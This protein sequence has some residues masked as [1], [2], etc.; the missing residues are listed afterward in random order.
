MAVLPAS[1]S[2]HLNAWYPQRLE[3]GKKAT[4][5]ELKSLQTLDKGS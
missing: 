4:T 1:M 2:V 3:D 5:T